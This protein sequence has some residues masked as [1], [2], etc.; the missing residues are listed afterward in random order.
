MGRPS[1][2][3]VFSVVL[4]KRNSS[5][6]SFEEKAGLGG[7]L[8]STNWLQLFVQGILTL[9]SSGTDTSEAQSTD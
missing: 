3:S 4:E 7:A 5:S 1:S 2:M 8:Y 9:A 6:H